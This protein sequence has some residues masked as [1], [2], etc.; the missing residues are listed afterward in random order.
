MAADIAECPAPGSPCGSVH[1]AF[2]IPPGLRR[3]G[4]GLGCQVAGQSSSIIFCGD[5]GSFLEKLDAKTMYATHRCLKKSVLG[6]SGHPNK[7]ATRGIFWKIH[8]EAADKRFLTHEGL[9]GHFCA[10]S[11]AQ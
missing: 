1:L 10:L 5:K 3:A 4:A 6:A 8:P 11:C 2:C 9:Y 7:I